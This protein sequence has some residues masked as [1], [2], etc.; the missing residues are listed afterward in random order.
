MNK[1]DFFKY[2]ALGLLLTNTLL[3][4]VLFFRPG[5]P[6]PPH[7]RPEQWVMERL[8]LNDQQQQEFQSLVK[9]HR[10]AVKDKQQK[11]LVAK[12]E[13]YQSLGNT[14]T[15]QETDKLLLQVD[16]AQQEMERLH[17]NHFEAVRNLCRPDQMKAFQ[18]LTDEL[19]DLF[20]NR[21][22]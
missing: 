7:V 10:K 5:G 8:N 2:S 16:R 12:Q 9:D 4:G 13:L 22:R 21:R 17:F 1:L 20:M 6:P 14:A 18:S 15:T 11:L 3:L 19:S